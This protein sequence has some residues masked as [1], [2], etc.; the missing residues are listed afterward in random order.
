MISGHRLVDPSRVRLDLVASSREEA[1][2]STAELL[3]DDARIGSWEQF[4]KSIGPKQVVDLGGCE[5]GICLAH[6]RSDKV[7]ELALSA[8]RLASPISGEV[9]KIIFVFAIPLAMSEE[10]LRTVGALARRCKDGARVSELI[11]ATTPEMF[12]QLLEDWL[13]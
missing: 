3:Q 4:W 10:Y 12:A 11:A 5:C 7:R 8:A 9:V 2:R 13:G 6:G 1:V